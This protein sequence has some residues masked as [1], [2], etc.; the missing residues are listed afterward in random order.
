M[1][2]VGKMR[3]CDECY[4]ERLAMNTILKVSKIIINTTAHIHD[5][6]I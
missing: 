3:A 5:E 1:T 6:L 4:E 2:K